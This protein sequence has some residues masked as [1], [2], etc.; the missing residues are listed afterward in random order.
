[1]DNNLAKL[2]NF[3]DFLEEPA[4][5]NKIDI[6]TIDELYTVSNEAQLINEKVFKGG[7]F[8][9]IPSNVY[10]GIMNNL[11][12]NG[13]KCKFSECA[14]VFAI[15]SYFVFNMQKPNGSKKMLERYNY[16]CYCKVDDICNELNMDKRNFDKSIELLIQNGYICRKTSTE[17]S[18]QPKYYFYVFFIPNA[19]FTVNNSDKKIK[20]PKGKG[21]VNNFKKNK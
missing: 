6:S 18:I 15:Y 11:Y 19:N 4:P 3:N 16:S 21:N 9:R 12:K 20:R 17:F 5:N 10:Y 2:Y 13:E 14:C 7:N 8:E 1:M